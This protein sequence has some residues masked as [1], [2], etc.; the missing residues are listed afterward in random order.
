MVKLL[1][2]RGDI[3]PNLPGKKNQTPLWCSAECGHEGVVKLLL[4]RKDVVHNRR[5]ANGRTPLVCA[6]E[7]GYEGVVKILLEREREAQG[8]DGKGEEQS[9]GGREGSED[10]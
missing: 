2:E 9:K 10:R 4:K 3:N 1:L 5:D 8:G 7:K 6:T